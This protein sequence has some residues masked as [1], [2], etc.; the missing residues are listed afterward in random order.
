[1]RK[2][3]LPMALASLASFPVVAAPSPE[4]AKAVIQRYAA[5]AK[6]ATTMRALKAHWS[7]RFA[8]ENEALYA[9]Q[10]A[11]LP[12]ETRELI[13]KRLVHG[14]AETAQNSLKGLSAT[15]TASGCTARAALPG[16]FTQTYRLVEERGMMVID[17]AST[18]SGP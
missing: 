16:G 15:C 5:T 1:V 7:S 2:L 11:P 6:G 10:V 3:V 17:G 8:K 12:P 13:E 14:V 9:Q 4:G 18:A